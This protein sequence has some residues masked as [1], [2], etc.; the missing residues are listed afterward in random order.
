MYYVTPQSLSQRYLVHDFKGL[1][2]NNAFNKVMGW[3]IVTNKLQYIP[4]RS[5]HH[6]QRFLCLLAQQYEMR[7]FGIWVIIIGIALA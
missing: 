6:A 2:F 7:Q 1:S 3:E 5:L 4:F